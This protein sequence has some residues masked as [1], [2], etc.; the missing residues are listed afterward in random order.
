MDL[1]WWIIPGAAGIVGLLLTFAGM[2]RLMKLNLMTGGLRFLFG[3]GFLGLAGVGTF[4]G[5]NLQTYKRL[6]YEQPV[7]EISFAAVDG[8]E[9]AY[10]VTIAVPESDDIK[11]FVPG[12]VDQPCVLRGDEFSMGAQVITFEPMANMLGYDSVYR[13]E[14]VEGRNNQR[15]TTGSV[16]SATSNGLA[17]SENPGL[18]VH[19]L[20]REQGNR[21]GVKGTQFGSA[22]YAPMQDGLSYQ[23]VL[24]QDALTLKPANPA[25]KRLMQPGD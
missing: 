12:E 6:T 23:I 21:I 20:A 22:V 24:T 18:D 9:D 2:G 17:L 3:I 4:A 1:L 7:A 15:Y 14:Y 8:E 16:T 13:L 25:T 10:A 11:C 5:L 19:A